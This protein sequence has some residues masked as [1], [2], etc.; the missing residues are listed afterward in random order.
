MD[1]SSYRSLLHIPNM[2]EVTG[3][4]NADAIVSA[5]ERNAPQCVFTLNIQVTDMSTGMACV[6]LVTVGGNVAATFDCSMVMQVSDLVSTAEAWFQ[7][8]ERVRFDYEQFT[9][10]CCRM[11]LVLPDGRSFADL[12]VSTQLGNLA[13]SGLSEPVMSSDSVTHLL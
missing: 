11:R 9:G 10:V 5:L 8:W 1:V 7:T 3:N 13:Y 2:D 4:A 12:P 6:Q